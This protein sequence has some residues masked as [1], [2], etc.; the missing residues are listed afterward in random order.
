[1]EAVLSK[2]D[3][4]EY[5]E[6]CGGSDTFN[7]SFVSSDPV[8]CYTAAS[9]FANSMREQFSDAEKAPAV[10]CQGMIVTLSIDK[11]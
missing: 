2:L 8:E 11:E 6:K 7:F 4:F 1:M 5:L 10:D 9:A 3:A